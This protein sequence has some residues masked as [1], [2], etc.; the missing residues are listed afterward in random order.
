MGKF[1]DQVKRFERKSKER[2]KAVARLS[3]QETASM[4]Q[5]T[6]PEGGRMRIEFGFLR[7]SL[8]GS[9]HSMPTGPTANEG[10]VKYPPGSVAAGEPLSVTLLRWDPISRDKIYIGWT[11][12]YARVRESK[13]GFM[14]GAVEKWDRTVFKAVK[15]AEA[16]FG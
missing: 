15:R 5:R 7:A 16:G 3:V 13:D 9:L 11:A 8:Q 6:R 1:T 4:A 14:R 2:L 12:N 10:G